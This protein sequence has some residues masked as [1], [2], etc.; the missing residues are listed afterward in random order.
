MLKKGKNLRVEKLDS[1]LGRQ[2]KGIDLGILFFGEKFEN[3]HEWEQFKEIRYSLINQYEKKDEMVYVFFNLYLSDQQGR[4]QID[5]A[6]FTKDGPMIIELKSY[7]GIVTG[8]ESA[9][10]KVKTP[11][12][13]VKV[14]ENVYR[15]LERQKFALIRKLDAFRT[16]ELIAADKTFFFVKCCAYFQK[17]SSYDPY[18]I[19]FKDKK[20]FSVITIDDL[21]E[22]IGFINSSRRWSIREMDVIA[23]AIGLPKYPPPEKPIELKMWLKALDS[24]V[25]PLI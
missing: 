20:W 3:R 16:Q 10:W 13:E 9:E 25:Y 18:Q 12:T 19:S 6:I 14:D 17:G 4:S 2:G 22:E 1:C 11:E 7:K 8:N 23:K 15:Q 5:V 24:Y 21:I